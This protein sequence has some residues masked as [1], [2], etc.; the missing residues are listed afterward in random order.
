M[1]LGQVVKPLIM[2]HNTLQCPITGIAVRLAAVEAGHR[3]RC[4][5]DVVDDRDHN[6]APCALAFRTSAKFGDNQPL[7][8]VLGLREFFHSPHNDRLG[9]RTTAASP[10]MGW[11]R[12]NL[13]VAVATTVARRSFRRVRSERRWD[14][15][16]DPLPIQPLKR[17]PGPPAVGARHRS[18]VIVPQPTGRSCVGNNGETQLKR[19]LTQG[20]G[21][22]SNLSRS[23]RGSALACS[24][25]GAAM[26]EVV[27]IE[28]LAGEPG[29]IAY[30]CPS[31]G[32]VTSV[33]SHPDGERLVGRRSPFT[34]V[35][36]ALFRRHLSI[37]LHQTRRFQGP[38]YNRAYI[39][40]NKSRR[41]CRI[42]KRR[43]VG[44]PSPAMSGDRRDTLSN[45]CRSF[46]A[47]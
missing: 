45:D 33:L 7:D 31:C 41:A 13:K 20:A 11:R 29:L 8:L 16:G 6:N 18:L 14:R 4:D 46:A 43:F 5:T 47:A 40:G 25:C 2:R 12:I 27:R 17:W 36:S 22:V 28:P 15:F 30:E 32:Y 1:D 26:D 10:Y 19:A 24:R 39:D 9:S 34:P 38:V 21:I 37:R 35:A 44:R 42:R 3:P 23:K